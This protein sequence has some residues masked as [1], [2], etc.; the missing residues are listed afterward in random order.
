M[1]VL[2]KIIL[3]E[4]DKALTDIINMSPLNGWI[5][6]SHAPNSPDLNQKRL[7]YLIRNLAASIPDKNS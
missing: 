4:K 5:S 2:A 7:Q 1:M 3:S 6:L